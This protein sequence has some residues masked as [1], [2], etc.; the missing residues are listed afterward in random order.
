MSGT[1]KKQKQTTAN[2]GSHSAKPRKSSVTRTP[3][4]SRTPSETK[5]DSG[6]R[7]GRKEPQKS[8]SLSSS[9]AK[10]RRTKKSTE[11]LAQDALAQRRKEIWKG[12]DDENLPEL[13]DAQIIDLAENSI[14]YR[15]W[16]KERRKRRAQRSAS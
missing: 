3:S 7:V 13:K 6:S 4:S 10:Q 9:I 15:E 12:Y 14:P 1:T 16:V 5:N 8:S 11:S 2:T